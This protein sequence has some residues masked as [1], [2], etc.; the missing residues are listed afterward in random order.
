MCYAIEGLSRA[1]FDIGGVGHLLEEPVALL[2]R[3][4]TEAASAEDKRLTSKARYA[5]EYNRVL[6]SERA[7]AAL[8][9]A[10]YDA[11]A[12]KVRAGLTS[13]WRTD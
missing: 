4:A 6:W 5:I 1:G 3:V 9:A 7:A 13:E 10:G 2:E 11:E 12:A 8:S